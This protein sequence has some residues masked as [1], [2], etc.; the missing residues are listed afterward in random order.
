MNKKSAARGP[1]PN[2]EIIYIV[3]HKPDHDIIKIHI[4]SRFRCAR[5]TD[6]TDVKQINGNRRGQ[7]DDL[8]ICK[9]CK[10]CASAEK[11][12][13]IL[14]QRTYQI[15]NI[16]GLVCWRKQKYNKRETLVNSH[17]RTNKQVN[18]IH[19]TYIFINLLND[20]RKI[21]ITVHICCIRHL[22]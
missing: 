5:N 3:P 17:W 2:D 13:T 14:I 20:K 12:K 6:E 4:V 15:N 11:K 7:W 1:L 18:S 19:Q 10:R 9:K 16:N 8:T 21:K 22:E